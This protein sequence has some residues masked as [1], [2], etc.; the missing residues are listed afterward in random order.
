VVRH[1]K[2]LTCTVTKASQNEPLLWK[3][4]VLG[5][6][7]TPCWHR[8]ILCLA[9]ASLHAEMFFGLRGGGP[10]AMLMQEDSAKASK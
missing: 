6:D 10:S 9:H 5:M 2:I 3:I 8:N 1:H 4:S 7:K